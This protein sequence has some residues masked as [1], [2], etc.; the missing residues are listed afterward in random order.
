MKPFRQW[1]EE[2]PAFRRSLLK[3]CGAEPVTEASYRET[4]RALE[5]GWKAAKQPLTSGSGDD[6]AHVP[7][8]KLAFIAARTEALKY[9][10]R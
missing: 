3:L 7:F 5:A 4:R 6:W 1:A 2:D 10:R 8:G 9:V